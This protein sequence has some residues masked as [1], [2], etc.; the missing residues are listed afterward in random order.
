MITDGLAAA[1]DAFA[2]QDWKQAYAGLSSADAARTQLSAGD[3]E[4]LAIAAY[5]LG[6]SVNFRREAWKGRTDRSSLPSSGS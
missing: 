2:R 3:L 5:M 6:K 1:R 4:C